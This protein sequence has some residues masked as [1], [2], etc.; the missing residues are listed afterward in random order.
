[1]RMGIHL[2]GFCQRS[3]CG[4]EFHYSPMIAFEIASSAQSVA[5]RKPA[6]P[7]GGTQGGA[8]SIHV[9]VKLEATQAWLP[10]KMTWLPL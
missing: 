1:M 9:T 5:D 7:P 10:H 4:S 6:K 2:G 8:G 3:M